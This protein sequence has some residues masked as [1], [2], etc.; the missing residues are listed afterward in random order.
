MACAT[1][2]RSNSCDPLSPNGNSAKR[3]RFCLST[4]SATTPRHALQAR[5]HQARSSPFVDATPKMTSEEIEANVH[6][7]MLRLQ[8]RRQLF[9]Q[10]GSP[11]YA[12][13]PAVFDTWPPQGAKADQPVFTFRQVGLIVER[14]VSEREKQ[15]REVYDS[16]LSAKL[17]E[18]YDAFVKF[19][20][21]QIQ[22]RYDSVM[23]SYLS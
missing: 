1:L 15:L 11:D 5:P 22:R 14:M 8:R 16:V 20:H 3:Q 13:S 7:E 17:A 18:Q 2:K 10:Q 19:T 4:T 9:F 21:D 23:P 6:D 12:A